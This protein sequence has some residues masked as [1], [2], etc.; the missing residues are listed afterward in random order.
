[1]QAF[2]GNIATYTQSN[3]YLNV[4]VPGGSCGFCGVSDGARFTP[5]I[6]ALADDFEVV[7]TA[8]E[9]ERV[10]RDSTK[11]L[12]NLQLLL[13]GSTTELGI[14]ITGDVIDNQGIS[15]HQIISYYRN[16]A[17]IVY[18]LTRSLIVGQYYA[19]QFRIRRSDGVSYL[20]YRTSQDAAWTEFAVPAS[21]P[22]TASLVP[23]L[24]IA[25]GDGGGTRANSSFKVTLDSISISQ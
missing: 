24:V 12:S 1:M 14:Y 23:S 17:N 15:G 3:G 20:A 13:T 22:A 10:S 2:N 5:R 7:L 18:P 16:G 9:V 25:S 6:S 8:E 21:F 11:P 4:T 19:F